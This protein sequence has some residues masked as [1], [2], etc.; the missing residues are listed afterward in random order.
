MSSKKWQQ[1]QQDKLNKKK[2]QNKAGQKKPAT[3]RATSVPKKGTRS[4]TKAAQ[5]KR[6]ISTVFSGLKNPTQ[7]Q[8][9]KLPQKII[10][11]IK[12]LLLP[13][14]HP[15][16]KYVTAVV[17]SLMVIGVGLLLQQL[18]SPRR[19]TAKDNFAVSSQIYDRNGKLLYEI[20]DKEN[21]VPIK[22]EDLPP[23]VAQA[24]I[25]IED[26]NFYHHWGFDL[27]AL[28]EQPKNNL[29]SDSTEG[30]STITQQLVKNA[31]LTREKTFS[32]KA[33]ELVLSIL[34]EIMYSKD[35]NL[36]NVSQLHPLWWHCRRYSSCFTKVL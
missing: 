23:Y 32:R 31:F 15:V 13:V 27:A 21:R 18:P 26:K 6:Q 16:L 20:Y 3:A 22:L 12:F 25:A 14:T 4:L 24:T 19:L 8:K 17:L 2:Q 35:R 30:G 33:K 11:A 10:R 34:T 1:A 9:N 29:T 36:R 28:L 5:I 7:Q